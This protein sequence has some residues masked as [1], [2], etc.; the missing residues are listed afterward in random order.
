MQSFGFWGTTDFGVVFRSTEQPPVEWMRLRVSGLVPSC[1]AW[2]CRSFGYVIWRR[3]V[4]VDVD[5]MENCRALLSLLI[6]LR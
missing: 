5:G 6:C 1:Y 4:G 3:V 2:N